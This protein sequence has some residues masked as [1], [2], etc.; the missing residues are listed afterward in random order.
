MSF[1]LNAGNFQ[2]PGGGP[3]ANG[4][5]TLTLSNISA[6]VTA[7]GGAATPSYSITLDSN[8]NIPPGTLVLGNSELTPSGTFYTASLVTSLGAS[9]TLANSIWIIGPSAPYAGTLFPDVN[10]YPPLSI[11]GIVPGALEITANG[12]L[13]ASAG[14]N[15]WL[16]GNFGSPILG[17][18]Y[19][20]DG[21]G[22]E[23]DF[24]KRT[25]SADTSLFK[26]KDTGVIAFGSAADAA[27]SRT[28]T[29][30]LAIGNGTA[31]DASGTVNAGKF[32]AGSAFTPSAAIH[33]KTASGG[34]DL[35]LEQTVDA[36]MTVNLKNTVQSWNF[37]IRQ[38]SSEAFILRDATSLN[39]R[40]SIPTGTGLMTL[41]NA[42]DTIV[43][44]ATTDTLTNKTLTSPTL[45]TP[46]IG[47]E[48]ISSSPRMCWGVDFIANGNATSGAYKQWVLDKAITITR[49]DI[50]Y[51]GVT[52]LGST[53]SAKLR[54]TD[55]TTNTDVSMTNGA[56]SD[57]SGAISANYAAGATLQIKT[58]AGVG[59]TQ[60][61]TNLTVT[62]QYKMQ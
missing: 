41:P 59:Y 51:A 38:A 2:L 7:T 52:G 20:G 12:G 57:T 22:W 10:V 46:K 60:N 31:G 26:F 15:L 56:A 58:V 11:S 47:T 5:L 18:I 62:I 16:A 32:A 3:V 28:A 6:T 14:T 19:I 13:P 37:G 30:T 42:T 44:R 34:S 43:G 55:G 29:G 21:T 17:K 33:S 1:L 23:L 24:A 4:V 50:V 35:I 9:V 61:P 40:L 49:I 27:I 8:G 45:T 39:D 25:G 48:T 54:V 36:N 53:T